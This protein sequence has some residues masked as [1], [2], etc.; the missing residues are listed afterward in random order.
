MLF[1][2]INKFE[3]ILASQSPRRQQLLKDLGVDYTIKTKNI[4]EDFP[5]N[6]KAGEIPLYLCNKKAKAYENSLNSNTILITADTV[7]WVNNQV[8][9]K[10]KDNIDAKRMLKL[11]SGN[12]HE[13]YTGVCLKSNNKTKSF[14]VSTK[15]FFKKLSEQEID[16]YINK[17]K[18]FDKAGSYGVQEFIGYIGIEKIEGSY[19]NVM[20]LPVKELYEE[21]LNF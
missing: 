7:V 19:Y 17:F 6:L 3:I 20:G 14:C 16:Y 18:P 2:E 13:V 5:S 21:L 15:V 9:N 1:K 11:L 12:K 10:P 4:E 8:L